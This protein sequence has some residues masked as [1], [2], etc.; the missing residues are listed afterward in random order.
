MRAS[1]DETYALRH[2]RRA[3]LARI[4]T[5]SLAE[6]QR[7]PSRWPI[8]HWLQKHPH[9]P[10]AAC[11][12]SLLWR[13]V[14]GATHS[15]K[16]KLR[17]SG[18]YTDPFGNFIQNCFVATEA[19]PNAAYRVYFRPDK[20]PGTRVEIVFEMCDP[21]GVTGVTPVNLP[22]Y[23]ATIFYDGSAIG[24]ITTPVHFWAA[25]F[26][27]QSMPR[28]LRRGVTPATLIA[29]KLLPN[30][31]PAELGVRSKDY[32]AFS[33]TPMT[34]AG[35]DPA[36]T[37]TGERGDIGIVTEWCA[38][39]ILYGHNL[40]TVLAQGEAMAT[41]PI[42]HRDLSTFAPVNLYNYPKH[43]QYP[44][45]KPKIGRTPLI[46]DN[47]HCPA[48]CYLPYLL[49]GDLFYLEGMQFQVNADILEQPAAGRFNTIGRYC[50]WPLRN[51]LYAWT[52]TAPTG[53]PSWLLP[54]S[55]FM[56]V[57]N[58][59]LTYQ[60]SFMRDPEPFRSV[61]R[62]AGH[63]GGRNSGAHGTVSVAGAFCTPWQIDFL[64]AVV[65]LCIE[66]GAP[67]ASWASTMPGRLTA[68][69]S[70]P[71]RVAGSAHIQRHI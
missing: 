57:A 31:D 5:L 38:D 37:N 60:A 46:Y 47:G 67:F 58:D 19:G 29:A 48:P 21:T 55:Y 25:R 10:V 62:V 32:P 13:M 59:R 65:G 7:P 50:A 28:A 12:W 30:Y 54:Q 9:H 44:N 4:L 18:D 22:G 6:G 56:H 61:F 15:L 45:S 71:A 64:N 33:Y 11:R 70:A 16:R 39:Y 34:T 20:A 69:F 36:M 23:T 1:V 26:R 24:S 66:R 68:R 27:W 63:A 42:N 52:A 51:D 14:A 17:I 49:T 53:L 8:G 3:L 41:W 2:T 40:P 43:D 35:L